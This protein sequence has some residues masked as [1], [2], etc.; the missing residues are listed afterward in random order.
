MDTRIYLTR[1]IAETSQSMAWQPAAVPEMVAWQRR[2]RARVRKLIGGCSDPRSP[3]GARTIETR[4]FPAYRRETVR[5]QSRADF[6]VLG[7]L[8]LPHAQPKP[9][10]AVLCLPGHGRGVDSIVGIEQDGRVHELGAPSDYQKDFALQCVAH[11]YVTL[12]I[13]QMSFGRRRDA[14][15]R[16]AGPEASSCTRDATALLMLGET[17]TGWR[18]RDAIRAIDYLRTRPEVDPKRIATMGISGGGLTALFTACLDTRVRAAVV[19]GYLNTF[20]DSILAVDHCVDNYVPGLLNVVEMPDLAGL[21][22]PRALFAEGGSA[23]PIFPR[24]AFQT[25]C[26]RLQTIYSAFGA[27]DQFG[28]E[29]FEGEHEFHA[30]GAFRFLASRL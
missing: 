27:P 24:A 2:L 7:Y 12:A 30:V 25:A 20:R 10:P 15:A 8:L 21:I 4:E 29:A 18:V 11:G 5:F 19:S 26:Q 3:L 1:R 13:E 6:D 14:Q 22:A 23:D 16:E 9:G 28:F 17:M